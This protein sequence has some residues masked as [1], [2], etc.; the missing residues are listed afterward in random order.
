ML[1]RI[2]GLS[3]LFVLLTLGWYLVFPFVTGCGM[4]TTAVETEECEQLITPVMS[5][6]CALPPLLIAIL[7]FISTHGQKSKM[8]LQN[9]TVDDEGKMHLPAVIDEFEESIKQ[10]QLARSFMNIGG[11]MMIACCV[12]IVLAAVLMLIVGSFCAMGGATDCGDDNFESFIFWI[13]FGN[14]GIKL[15]LVVFLIS[16]IAKLVVEYQL[17]AKGFSVETK[18]VEHASPTVRSSCPACGAK[19]RF[20]N[21]HQ[22]E[23]QCPKCDHV[24]TVGM[25]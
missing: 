12:L 21:E 24:F 20:P 14:V 8:M 4:N 11:V 16:A 25:D 5:F 22:G 6:F 15:G 1:R 2:G 10:T 17:E 19:L 13:K 7:V 9:P 23:V 3:G 18:P